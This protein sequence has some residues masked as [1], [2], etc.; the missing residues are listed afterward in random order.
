VTTALLPPARKL[1]VAVDLDGTLVGFFKTE[2]GTEELRLRV[3]AVDLV[4]QLKAAGH[5]VLLWTFGNRTWWNEVVQAFPVL[6]DLFDEVYTRD[7]ELHHITHARGVAE[8]VKD[9]RV[10]KAD[11]LIDNDPR[12]REWAIRNG[13]DP[14]Q[15]QLVSQFGLG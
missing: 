10:L 2:K 1:R 3:E 4:R 7:D 13:F 11:M 15:Y 14:L 5:T 9:I 12:H 6:E 8:P